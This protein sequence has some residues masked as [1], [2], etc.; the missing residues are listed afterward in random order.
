MFFGISRLL[1]VPLTNFLA[2]RGDHLWFSGTCIV[3]FV[4][5]REFL[6]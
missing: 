4:S 1:P 6:K 3:S 5:D 2:E